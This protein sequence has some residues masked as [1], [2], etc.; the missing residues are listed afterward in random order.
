[1]GDRTELKLRVKSFQR[2]PVQEWMEPEDRLSSLC[3]SSCQSPAGQTLPAPGPWLWVPNGVPP[4]RCLG[5]TYLHKGETSYLAPWVAVR[6]ACSIT[7]SFQT[8]QPSLSNPIKQLRPPVQIAWKIWLPLSIFKDAQ[9]DIPWLPI[10]VATQNKI[11][12]N[13]LLILEREEGRER[14]RKREI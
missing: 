5:L 13:I 11:L 3:E 12:K 4:L 14:E 7:E 1:M 6:I 9:D 8:L 10:P 2:R